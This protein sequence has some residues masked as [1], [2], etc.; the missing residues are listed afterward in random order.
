ILWGC[1]ITKIGASDGLCGHIVQKAVKQAEQVIVIDP[2]RIGAVNQAK[3]WVQLNPGTDGALALAMINV[4]INDNL[5]DRD[6]VNKYT[7]G[8]EALSEHIKPFTP[9]WA[10]SITG[11]T[12]DKIRE[13][14]TVY[15][16]VKPAC[17][18]WGNGVDMSNCAF[19]TAHSIL[20]LKSI[21]GNIDRPGGD[22]FWVGPEG[23]RQ[24]SP[25]INQEIT[26]GQFLPPEKRAASVDAGKYEFFP[27]VHPP[28]LWK[29]IVN[30][31]PYRIKA[32]WIIGSN[33]L[34]TGTSPRETE[35]ALKLLDFVVVS[36][37][38][39]T[40]TAQL[41][42]LVLPAASWLEQND[43]ANFHKI[44]CVLSRQKL[45]QIGEAQD[46]REVILQLA[47]RLG[48]KEAFPWNTLDE[49]RDWVLNDTGMTFEQFCEKGI[50]TGTMRYYK[51]R[52]EG[53][54]T[55]S[56]KIELFSSIMDA[57]GS[58]PLPIYKEQFTP[59]FQ[60]EDKN[61]YPIML[62]KS[63]KVREYF[64]SEG[65]QIES[66]RKALPDPIMEIHPD[67]ASEIGINTGDWVWIETMEGRIKMRAKLFDGIAPGVISA[68]HG[69]WFP[70]E[71]APDYGWKKSN[72]NL[73]FGEKDYDFET[74]SESF[75][76][77]CRVYLA[78]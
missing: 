52:E 55:P 49:Y 50:A 66:L 69:W 3:H 38:F 30:S 54:H 76:V 25:L 22:V 17:I 27:F 78:Q 1:N 8:F 53:F 9:E 39:M 12:A 21:T 63:G 57:H 44:W 13:I 7:V 71:A 47:K 35:K 64:H 45:A 14:A 19:H 26:G 29:S 42:D 74:G 68:Q 2:R 23:F 41:A 59:G 60:P 33:P 58:S 10:S 11:I 36:D 56:N 31:D 75:N 46:D 18:Q 73:L 6:F 62:I 37:L 24:C 77:P 34:V 67:T 43:I 5:F 16:S 32:L 20:I 65:R 70:E 51:Y 72:V 61:E 40:P 4:I 48:L 15:A 28:T